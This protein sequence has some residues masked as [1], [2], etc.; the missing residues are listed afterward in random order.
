MLELPNGQYL[1]QSMAI[2]EYL[3]SVQPTPSL[4]PA[5]PWLKAKAQQVVSSVPLALRLPLDR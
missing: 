5:D 4:Y 3:E 1:T 2:M